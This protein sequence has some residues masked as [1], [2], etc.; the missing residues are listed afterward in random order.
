MDYCPSST[1]L[2][3]VGQVSLRV[4]NPAGHTVGCYSPC[5][6]LTMSNYNNQHGRHS[7]TDGTANPYC[8]PT[9]PVSSP[10]CRSGPAENSDWTRLIHQRCPNVYAYA[11]DDGVGLSTCP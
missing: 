5:S 1:N 3:G 9:P 2:Q 7:P 10:Q 8:C 4:R 6:I 11:Y